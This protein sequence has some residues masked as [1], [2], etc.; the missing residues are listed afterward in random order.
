[1]RFQRFLQ[2]FFQENLQLLMKFVKGISQETLQEFIKK[3][4]RNAP[5]YLQGL[6]QVIYQEL[7]QAFINKFYQV[8]RTEL[9]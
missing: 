2:E 1:M 5:K 9:L 3:V 6:F 8:F 4:S 7:I